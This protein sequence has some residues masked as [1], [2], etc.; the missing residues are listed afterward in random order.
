M[1]ANI[2]KFN[3]LLAILQDQIFDNFNLSILRGEYISFQT[4]ISELKKLRESILSIRP[5]FIP[6]NEDVQA[7]IYPG[8]LYSAFTQPLNL[9][10]NLYKEFIAI[11]SKKLANSDKEYIRYYNEIIEA[12]SDEQ[13]SK[14]TKQ[15]L[16]IFHVNI[17]IAEYDHTL[18]VEGDMLNKLIDFSLLLKKGLSPKP[19]LILIL[20]KCQLLKSKLLLR[21][22]NTHEDD[23]IQIYTI[24]NGEESSISIAEFRDSLFDKW[25][26]Y[27]DAHYEMKDDWKA[28]IKASYL[29]IKSKNLNDCTVQELCCLVKYHK[30]VDRQFPNSKNAINKIREE[31]A[32]RLN[33]A[34]SAKLGFD[35]Y[36][37][38]IVLN[39][40][41]NNEFSL[42]CEDPDTTI[43]VSQK[44]Y[45]EI[46]D[47]QKHTGIKN[48]FPQTKFLKF[49]LKELKK[50]YASNHAIESID[51][52]RKIIDKCH[53]IYTAY[54]N[55]VEWSKNNYNYVF[56]LPFDECLLEISNE[57]GSVVD[58]VF[59]SS[60]F[61]MPILKKDI[62]SE[63]ETNMTEVTLLEYT[64]KAFENIK[65]E[66]DSLQTLKAEIKKINDDSKLKDVKTIEVL[67]I[68]AALISFVAA[69][70]PT[71]KIIETPLQAAMF[72][73]AL[74]TS[75]CAFI[76]VLL[77]ASRGL[78]TFTTHKKTIYNSVF[79]AALFW[80]LLIGI[81]YCPPISKMINHQR[82]ETNTHSVIDTIINNNNKTTITINR[83]T[84]KTIKQ[85]DSLRIK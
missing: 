24:I 30:D 85:E 23:N 80:C 73:L 53:S 52:C 15:N 55:N 67:G 48:F 79:L 47:I 10:I 22:K 68:F 61:L 6:L 28:A 8:S 29:I 32:V 46:L 50:N 83:D 21:R 72:M 74:S 3:D 76:V 34:K 36:A 38:Q 26:E 60:S 71:F 45:E 9:A 19:Y 7:T 63:F 12:Y 41:I 69:S 4:S 25:L 27:L 82:T 13:F 62:M 16:R 66:I 59:I 39:Y 84:S 31:I 2:K 43:Q 42:I 35:I 18:S 57:E 40:T 37:F 17:N 33:N 81:S 64:V 77:A 11:I 56:Q 78:N 44:F 54:K 58:K 51:D 65:T 14:E 75:L 49:L 1:Q 20:K 70:L 5:N